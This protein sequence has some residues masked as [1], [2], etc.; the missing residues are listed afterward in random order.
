MD[1]HGFLGAIVR[2]GPLLT[3]SLNNSD[4]LTTF[5]VKVVSHVRQKTWIK[6]TNCS[7]NILA[8]TSIRSNPRFSDWKVSMTSQQKRLILF[9]EWN[10]LVYFFK[11][12]NVHQNIYCNYLPIFS[13]NLQFVALSTSKPWQVIC[14]SF[15]C[16]WLLVLRIKT[17][18]HE[19]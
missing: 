4:K 10:S 18:V 17:Y 15:M 9:G 1:D 13:H 14:G 5:P 2:D 19:S 11:G 3:L 12:V 7:S 16:Q 8:R 6:E